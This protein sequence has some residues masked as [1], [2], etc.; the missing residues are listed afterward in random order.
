MNNCKGV[1][2]LFPCRLHSRRDTRLLLA[3][4]WDL[5]WSEIIGKFILL[6]QLKTLNDSL[7]EMRDI[8]DALQ[9]EATELSEHDQELQAQLEG[10]QD[11]IQRCSWLIT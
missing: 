6:F 4:I 9:H 1:F 7:N 5:I 8:N 3:V 2:L 10:A 11:K